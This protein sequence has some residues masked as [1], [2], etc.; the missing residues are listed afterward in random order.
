MARKH[1]GRIEVI[2]TNF[3]ELSTFDD[4]SI[5][6]RFKATASQLKKGTIPKGLRWD[7]ASVKRTEQSIDLTLFRENVAVFAF[8]FVAPPDFS[9]ARLST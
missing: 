4:R 8:S 3:D 7:A 9:R 2:V 6:V 5:Y 1:Y